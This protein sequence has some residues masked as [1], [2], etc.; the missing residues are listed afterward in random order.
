M[1]IKITFLPWHN[2]T[3]KLKNKNI[4]CTV[5]ISKTNNRKLKQKQ[6]FKLNKSIK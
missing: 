6:K 4:S 3:S 5:Y 2:V 1:S